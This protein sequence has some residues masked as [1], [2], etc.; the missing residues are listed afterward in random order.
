MKR[1]I[2]G[3][4]IAITV[5]ILISCGATCNQLKT[6]DETVPINSFVKI[7]K[8]ITLKRCQIMDVKKGDKIT[9]ERICVTKA[10]RSSASG[11]VVRRAPNGAFVLTAAHVCRN[12]Y[13]KTMANITVEKNEFSVLTLDM[14]SFPVKVLEMNTPS[15]ICLVWVLG[16]DLKEIKM[17]EEGPKHGELVYNVAAPMGI[18]DRNVVPVFSGYFSGQRGDA[19]LYSIPAIGGSS[20][21]PVFNRDGELVGLIHSAFVGFPNLSLSPTFKNL[22][23]FI[24][25]SIKDHKEE[26]LG[27]TIIERL[28]KI[29]N[30]LEKAANK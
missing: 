6:P 8:K 20:G 24:E 27:L 29:A 2:K 18:F 4:S 15:D 14:R 10:F 22:M 7:E 9:K 17:A 30:L 25:K 28:D 3:L 21:S 16:L 23:D 26:Y 11:S 1:V 13:L 12:D 19:A 5:L